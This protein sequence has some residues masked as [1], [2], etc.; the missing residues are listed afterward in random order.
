MYTVVFNTIIFMNIF[1]MFNA[2][3][4]DQAEVYNTVTHAWVE[5]VP[6]RTFGFNWRNYNKWFF[7]IVFFTILFQ[8]FLVQFGGRIIRCTPMNFTEWGM[9]LIFGFGAIFWHMIVLQIS[10][11]WCKC[12]LECMP[13]KDYLAKQKDRL[14]SSSVY[15]AEVHQDENLVEPHGNEADDSFH[16]ATPMS[17]KDKQV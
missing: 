15:V 7:S 14:T 4:L 8:V 6:K 5:H 1:N 11:N 3:V 13:K 12:C 2:R 10:P 17:D 9:S 16:K